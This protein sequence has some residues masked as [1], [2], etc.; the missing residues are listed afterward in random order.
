MHVASVGAVPLATLK[1]I[2][3]TLD[4]NQDTE[5]WQH[6]LIQE[7]RAEGVQSRVFLFVLLFQN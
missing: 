5:S 6:L 2:D 4:V 1:R 3:R 7:V